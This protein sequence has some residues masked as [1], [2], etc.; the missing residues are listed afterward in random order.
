VT[1]QLDA[2]EFAELAGDLRDVPFGHTVERVLE[3]VVKALS[4]AYAGI[5]V[6]ARGRVETVAAT[7]P[8]VAEL[9]AIQMECDQGPDL[10]V[11]ADRHGVLI[12]HAEVDERWP[13]WSEKVVAAGIRSMPGTRL[14]PAQTSIGSLNFF[15]CVATPRKTTSGCTSW[16]N[17]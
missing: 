11:I 12:R 9:D 5:L 3:F 17:A 7:H 2:E 1:G 4:C 8:L 10:E 13:Q 14:Y 15:D 6:H 16:P